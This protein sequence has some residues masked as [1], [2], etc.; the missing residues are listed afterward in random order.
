MPSER[1][2][3]L[4]GELR[5]TRQKQARLRHQVR[6]QHKRLERLRKAA[7]LA[8]IALGEGRPDAAQTLLEKGLNS[9]EGDPDP[10]YTPAGAK[11]RKPPPNSAGD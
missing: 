4:M 8:L 2:G 9:T 11:R 5:A 6:Y 10:E 3:K 7:D 1:E